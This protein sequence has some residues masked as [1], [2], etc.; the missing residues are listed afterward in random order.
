MKNIDLPWLAKMAWRDSRSNK[1]KLFLFLAAVSLGIAALVGITSF[2]ETLL[3]E[4]N[5]QAKTLIGADVAISGNIPLIDSIASEFRKISSE[6]AMESSFSSMVYF[7]QTEGTRLVQVKAITG[8]FPFYGEIETTPAEASIGFRL[9]KQAIVDDKLMVQFN[10]GIGDSLKVGNTTF[11]IVG[12]IDKIAGQTSMRGS[13]APVVY[14]PYRYLGETGLLQKGSRINYTSYFQL[15]PR[16]DTSGIW[17]PL[18]DYTERK[19]YDV[20]T[21][22]ERKRETA[23]AFANLSNFLQLVAFTALLM[24]C[25]GVASAINVYVKSKYQSVAILRCLGMKGSNAIAIFLIQVLGFGFIGSLLGCGLGMLLHLVLPDITKDFLPVQLGTEP[26]WEAILIGMVMGIS[27]SLLFGLLS[28]VKLRGISPIRSIRVG[29]VQ[30]TFDFFTIPIGGIIF[31]FLV[32]SVYWQL[33]DFSQSLY[34]CFGLLGIFVI[35]WGLGKGLIGMVKKLLPESMRYVWRQGFS[36]L[37]RPNNQT[38]ILVVTIGMATTFLAT[39]F[40]MQDILVQRVSLAEKN[41]RPNTVLFDIQTNQK[42]AIRQLTLDYDLPVLQEVPIVTMRLREIN[43]RNK[44]YANQD[45]IPKWV[46]DREYRV[47]YRDSLIDSEK[48]VEGEWSKSVGDS[49]FISMSNGYAENVGLKIGD[50]IV[51]NVQ[52]ALVKTYIGSFRKVDWT[53]V[54]TNFI[55]VFPT[56][57]L[58]KAP[59]FHVLA[60][61][62]DGSDL[63]ARYQRAVVRLYPNVSIID[64]ELILETL[65]EILGK[66]TF[67]IQFMAF[68]SIGTGIIVLIS[69]IVLSKIQRIKESMLLRTLGA[70]RKQIRAI[71]FAEYFF[72]GSIGALAGILLAILACSVLSEFVFEFTY[73][74]NFTQMLMVFTAV[75]LITLVVGI[76]N[77]RSVI[78]SPPMKVLRTE[79]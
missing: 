72:L 76:T 61:R 5:D 50:E 45:S 74:P 36:N 69:S 53:R 57:L 31:M 14:I 38:I 33:K 2:R 26:Y 22:N 54:Q 46:Y 3:G 7:P 30:N 59:Q 65:E 70:S 56:G 55:V 16:V 9:G 78:H 21:I 49:I 62:V 73:V 24:G 34:F 1:G 11:L 68:F 64:L 51:F 63:S 20:E 10:V 43:G 37:Y 8:D 12:A 47:T 67:V 79:E 39:L 6:E 48:I 58:E 29:D 40:F 15:D 77:N 42:Q 35:L 71:A 18:Y 75:S 44:T 52:G 25:L 32:C 19:G 41:N 13:L 17:S 66:V 28:L 27:I 4:I 23:E 60:T